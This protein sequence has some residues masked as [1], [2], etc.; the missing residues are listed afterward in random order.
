MTEIKKQNI[1][2]LLNNYK[3]LGVKFIEPLNFN[4]TKKIELPNDIK[5]L[6]NYV[7]H[8]NLCDLSKYKNNSIFSIGNFNSEIMMVGENLNFLNNNIYTLLEN[9]IK[10]VLEI[11]FNTIYM[12]NT[13]KCNVNNI[14]NLDRPI[15]LCKNYVIKQIELINPKIIITI[16]NAFYVFMNINDEIIDISGNL[17]NYNGIMII[18]LLDIEFVYK[19]PSYKQNMFNDLKKIKLLL[20]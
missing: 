5:E 20:E 3:L 12:T 1:L 14:A 6:E 4:N 2:D 16:G 10:N 8:C 19:N 15:E 18:P 13:L 11:D 7:S 17:Y 9:M